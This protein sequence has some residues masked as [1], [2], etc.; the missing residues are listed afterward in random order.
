MKFRPPNLYTI[1]IVTKIK[2]GFSN[3][4]KVKDF[5]IFMTMP[6]FKQVESN[7]GKKESCEWVCSWIIKFSH[8]LN[9]GYRQYGINIFSVWTQ[10]GYTSCTHKEKTSVKWITFDDFLRRVNF[11]LMFFKEELA[12]LLSA[13]KPFFWDLSRRLK[14]QIF[15]LG[16][17]HGHGT[18]FKK[19]VNLC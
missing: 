12:F 14:S 19:L 10:Y 6:S 2:K 18:D 7:Y 5:F 4:K 16:V 3:K 8:C 11:I 13:G 9:F 15:P 1:I 17:N